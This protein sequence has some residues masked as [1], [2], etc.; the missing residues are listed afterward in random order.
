VRF[1]RATH[2]VHAAGRRWPADP[3]A[4]MHEDVEIPSA[5]VPGTTWWSRHRRCVV[6]FESGWS[7]SIVWGTGT[8]SSN[9]DTFGFMPDAP[10]F[11]EEPT[12]VEVG[13]LDR[14]GELRQRDGEVEMYLDDD[15]LAALL[16]VLA[17]LPTCFD[18]GERAP[19]PA[20]LLEAARAAGLD[21]PAPPT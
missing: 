13:V 6:R 8:Y 14:D 9:H 17:K 12:T 20:E 19:T 21:L 4:T 18:Y 16:D 11:T 10:P 1:D 3:R 2:T 5:T 7:A 15:Q